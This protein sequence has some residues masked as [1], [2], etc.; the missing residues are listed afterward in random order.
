[1]REELSASG[2]YD[3]YDLVQTEADYAAALQDR[4]ER[5]GD[6]V[7]EI[8]ALYPAREHGSPGAALIAV[9]TDAWVHWY[10]RRVALALA[11]DR[12]P[13]SAPGPRRVSRW[14]MIHRY[15]NDPELAALGA[16]HKQMAHFVLGDFAKVL[17]RPYVP[18]AAEEEL[19]H[20]IQDTWIHF[21]AT[22]D[23]DGGPLGKAW[24]RFD[25]RTEQLLAIDDSTAILSIYHVEQCALWD[26]FP[27]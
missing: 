12:G 23:L 16:H 7:P 15:A 4:Y 6:I 26:R 27:F 5:L 24:P 20:R 3:D 18:T 21:A 17:D 14:L 19:T 25:G 13:G 1:M 2:V 22:G 11:G 8:L 9:D 10:M